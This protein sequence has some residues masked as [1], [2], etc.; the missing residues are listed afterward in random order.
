MT[1]R[2]TIHELMPKVM[3]GISAIGKNQRNEAQRFNFRGIDDVMN[4][5]QPVLVKHGVF[6]VPEVLTSSFERYLTKSGTT[7]RHAT[8]EIAFHFYGPAGDSVT[9]IAVGE[10]ADSGDKA[11]S[12]AAAIALKYALLQTFCI[13]TEEQRTEDPDGHSV[14]GPE[15]GSA[16][17]SD[18]LPGR[19]SA[20]TPPPVSAPAPQVR[21][22]RGGATT[23]GSPHQASGSG[24]D[25]PSLAPTDIC[26]KGPG[27]PNGLTRSQILKIARSVA[28]EHS[29]AP[30]SKY[31][32]IAALPPEVIDSVVAQCK[33]KVVPA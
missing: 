26:L 21:D 16:G 7:M 29:V 24:P 19:Q 28:Q 17:V 8:L 1:D 3:G 9:V 18:A 27:N 10:A 2:P 30:P 15:S 23:A 22:Q 33:G 20:G 12:K 6:Y 4:A 11:A 13:P 5:V 25:S 32:A 14:D 31:E